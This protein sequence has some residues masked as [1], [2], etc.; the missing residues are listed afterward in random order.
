MEDVGVKRDELRP[1]TK[2]DLMDW[3]SDLV[4]FACS[5]LAE[6]PVYR[7][8]ILEADFTPEGLAVKLETKNL[9]RLVCLLDGQPRYVAGTRENEFV[10][11]VDP[12]DRDAKVLTIQGH[13]WTATRTLELAAAAR[14][15]LAT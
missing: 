10:I 15:T 12:M 14:R 7:L 1:L 5:K 13:A 6:R 4:R 8:R 11:P 9:N 3:G 2:K